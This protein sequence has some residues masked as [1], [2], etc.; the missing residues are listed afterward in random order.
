MIDNWERFLSK[1]KV[2]LLMSENLKYNV[3]KELNNHGNNKHRA[4]LVPVMSAGQSIFYA[5]LIERTERGCLKISSTR[6][7]F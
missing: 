2:V 6:M 5:A 7:I 3:V 4:A 1:K